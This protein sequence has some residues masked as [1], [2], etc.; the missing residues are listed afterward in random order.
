MLPKAVAENSNAK[1]NNMFSLRETTCTGDVAPIPGY[2]LEMQ[3]TVDLLASPVFCLLVFSTKAL[4]FSGECV[5][6]RLQSGVTGLGK[7]NECR[8]ML[9][10]LDTDLEILGVQLREYRNGGEGAHFEEWLCRIRRAQARCKRLSQLLGQIDELDDVIL[11][12]CNKNG[13]L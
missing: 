11:G 8:K 13:E 7:K 12:Q 6:D 4:V 9:A 10:S 1:R 3:P 5:V 2:H